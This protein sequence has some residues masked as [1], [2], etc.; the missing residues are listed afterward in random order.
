MSIIDIIVIILVIGALIRG[1]ELGFVRQLFST[2]GFFGGLMLGAVLEPHVVVLAHTPTARIII[3]LASTLGMAVLLL[4]IGEI[5]GV[6]VKEKL[7]LQDKLNRIDTFLGAGLASISIFVL[8]WL[9]APVFVTLPYP[10]VQSAVRG[11]AIVSALN[12]TLP[13][14]PNIIADI[15]HLIA[16]N[17]FPD[18]FIGSEPLPSPANL[19]APAELAAAV[20]K[21][22]ASV[23]KIEGEGCGG[24]VEG[25]GFVVGDGIVA[26]NAHVVAGIAD[27]AIIDSNGKHRAAAIW[28][29]PDLDFAVLRAK[30]L[31]GGP[32]AFKAGHA[33]RSTPG[34]VLGYPGGG[35]FTASTAAVLDEFTAVG[36]NI[37]NEG[38]TERDVYSIRAGVEPGN[39]GGPLIN[40]NGDVIGVVFAASTAYNDVGYALSA[41]QVLAEI[42]LAKTQTQPVNTGSCAE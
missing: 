29:D 33:V 22:G 31:A 38:S 30:D 20:K 13:P 37:Y 8:V 19:P 17:G 40:T 10:N 35:P 3:T 15:G 14:A 27:P 42:D 2:V 24:I 25:S 39:S 21:D 32:L 12:R 11:S 1:Q 28:F 36:R 16:P 23:V 41:K 7:Q 18:V 34:G 9:C 5:A 26:T 6:I 4:F